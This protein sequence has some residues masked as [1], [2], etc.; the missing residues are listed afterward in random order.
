VGRVDL[1]K[2]EEPGVGVIARVTSCYEDTGISRHDRIV[3]T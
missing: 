2:W 3:E 1:R